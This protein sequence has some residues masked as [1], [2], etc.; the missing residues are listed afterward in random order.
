MRPNKAAQ[1]NASSSLQ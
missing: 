1:L